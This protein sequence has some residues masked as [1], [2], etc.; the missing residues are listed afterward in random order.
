M[1]STSCFNSVGMTRGNAN[2]GGVSETMDVVVRFLRPPHL[3]ERPTSEN[4]DTRQNM[5]KVSW[6]ESNLTSRQVKLVLNH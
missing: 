4:T 3:P 6:Q 5:E 2:F 1:V